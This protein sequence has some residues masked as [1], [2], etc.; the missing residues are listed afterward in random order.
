MI[1]AA[2]L[3]LCVLSLCEQAVRQIS[4]RVNSR[5]EIFMIVVRMLI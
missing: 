5:R 1:A 2:S 3:T 4:V